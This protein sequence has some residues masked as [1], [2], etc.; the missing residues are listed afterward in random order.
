MQFFE[1]A[2]ELS[3]KLL[4]D[5]LENEGY[6]IKIHTYHEKTAIEVEEKIHQSYVLMLKEL[7][8]DFK[9]KMEQE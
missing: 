6:I 7:Y 1:M 2:F 4:K 3:W 8:D 9:L 5:Y